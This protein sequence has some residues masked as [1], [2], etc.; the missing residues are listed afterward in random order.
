GP[1]PELHRRRDPLAAPAPRTPAAPRRVTR[2][3]PG[4]RSFAA[5]DPGLP[6]ARISG[7]AA[8]AA[9]E[10][11]VSPCRAAQPAAASGPRMTSAVPPGR[12]S[13]IAAT[14]PISEQATRRAFSML[15]GD[16]SPAGRG[17]DQFLLPVHDPD[18]AVVAQVELPGGWSASAPGCLRAAPQ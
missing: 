3:A 18:V 16:T 5:H 8:S 10:V 14:W 1:P 13:P 6:P 2:S 7:S 9:A 17:D 11:S 12:L 4:R 15:A